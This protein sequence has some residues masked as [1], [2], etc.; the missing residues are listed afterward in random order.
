MTGVQT[1]ALPIYV[2]FGKCN[3]DK[4]NSCMLDPHKLQE[5]SDA[6]GRL[7]VNDTKG[8]NLDATIEAVK[9]YSD[10]KIKII[11]GGDDKGVCLERL[12]EMLQPLDVEVFAI[13]SNAQKLMDLSQKF[14]VCATKCDFVHVAVE[15]ISKIL[16]ENGVGLLS[17]AAAS[18]DQ[19]SSYIERGEVF[20]ECVS[21]IS[22]N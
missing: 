6:K 9:R 8:T 2:L 17:P 10:K 20:M 18:L 14:R 19:F 22:V 1:C 15:K 11:L 12:F 3:V 4:I 16:D 13:G 21:K 5:L 7:W